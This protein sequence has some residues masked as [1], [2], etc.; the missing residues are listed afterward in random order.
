MFDAW[1][2]PK[3]CKSCGRCDNNNIKEPVTL[4]DINTELCEFCFDEVDD[5]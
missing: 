1:E 3:K 5:V 2:L 4:L